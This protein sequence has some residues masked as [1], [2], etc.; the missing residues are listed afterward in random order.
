MRS[1]RTSGKPY[2]REAPDVEYI[3]PLTLQRVQRV[4]QLANL[5]H[6]LF[7]LEEHKKRLEEG[8]KQL[9]AQVKEDIRAA[10]EEQ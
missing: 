4:A 2:T 10:L 9:E 8:I 3:D 7:K 5:K 6:Q 1:L